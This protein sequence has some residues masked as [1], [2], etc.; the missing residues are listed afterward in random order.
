MKHQKKYIVT[1]KK[2]Y[3]I[4]LLI[5]TLFMGIGYASINSVVLDIHG[6]ALAKDVDGLLITEVSY[7]NNVNADLNNSKIINA[8]QT[9]LQSRISLSKEDKDS[10]ITYQV[11]IFN[12]T[13]D[14]YIFKD[15][16]Y[17]TEEEINTYD[18]EN[19]DFYLEGLEI[20]DEL[21]SRSSISF[22]ITFHY[23]DYNLSENN[24]LNS[25][26]NFSFKKLYSIQYVNISSADFPTT[27]IE[28]DTLILNLENN[29]SSIIE[30]YINDILTNDYTYNDNILTINNV[31]G[32]IKIIGVI[33]SPSITQNNLIPISYDGQNWRIADTDN[34]WYNYGNQE[35]ANAVI[36]KSDAT[37]ESNT[38]IDIENDVRAMFVWI[39]RYEYKISTDM[40]N[41]I[42]IKFISKEQ[43]TASSGYT[44][45]PAFT[46]GTTQINGIWV[47]K[48]ETSTNQT[49]TC[50]INSTFENCNNIN[51]DTYILP[52]VKSLREQT[53]S[54]QFTLSQNFKQYLTND[55][56]N[57]HM[58]KNSEWTAVAYLSQSKYGKYGNLNY[59]SSNKEIY[60]NNSSE[61]YTG[62]SSGSP[63]YIDSEEKSYEYN[64]GFNNGILITEENGVG[65]S[66]TGN[67][68]GIYDMNGG[69]YEYV[70]GY[71]TT[72]STTFGA[73]SIY[74]YAG[75][76]TTPD[77]KYYDNYT[78]T[79]IDTACNGESCNG[80][81]FKETA[82]WY[83]DSA[84]FLTKE[85]PWVMRGG[86]FDIGVTSGIFSYTGTLGYSG[87]YATFRIALVE[88]N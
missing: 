88:E 34:E 75:F 78:S 40:S 29:S 63:D 3:P 82:G 39:P 59:S 41:E 1:K 76:T 17:I 84:S 21:V 61:L 19:I 48:F 49:S 81:G 27:I 14:T 10:T 42:Y 45:H 86:V 13:K 85:N 43:T 62:R 69:T 64:Y 57:S 53:I 2:I 25:Y 58:L 70:M 74:D 18:N 35:W 4:L 38:I 80:H 11:T 44:I 31:T 56:I 5:A 26:L 87:A 55:N 66:T 9:M 23:K 6:S 12:N 37:L 50:Y 83:N 60:V 28:G 73:T 71:L 52:N 51:I 67:I 65:A 16:N 68:T 72:A 15:I 24:I 77:S 33:E 7:Y 47:G 36:L 32:N 79:S 46:F 22:Y 30:V 54:T 20:G 8:Y